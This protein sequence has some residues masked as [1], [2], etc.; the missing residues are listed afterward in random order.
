MSCKILKKKVQ[1]QHLWKEGYVGIIDSSSKV[2][3]NSS[4]EAIR[5]LLKLS[6]CYP[7]S[8]MSTDNDVWLGTSFTEE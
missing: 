1:G 8:S 3:R 7:L 6:S 4:S 2:I 5:N